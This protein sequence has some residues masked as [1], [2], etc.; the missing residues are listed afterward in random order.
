MREQWQAIPEYEGIYEVSDKGRAARIK[1]YRHAGAKTGEAIRKIIKPDIVRGYRRV[2]LCRNNQKHRFM[3]HILVARVFIGL[4]PDDMEVN[5]KLGKEAGDGVDNLEYVT[6]S[7]NHLHAYRVLGKKSQKGSAHG[8]SKIT[9]DIARAIFDMRAHGHELTEVA[10]R[11]GVCIAT[12]SMI[13]NKKIWR[14][15]HSG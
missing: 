2:T 11:F 7:Q 5:H 4:R 3:V 14:H 15:I 12:V 9:E 10:K 13:A 8:R 6:R 1:S